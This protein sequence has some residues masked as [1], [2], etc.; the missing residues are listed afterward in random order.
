[1]S[2]TAQ[3]SHLPRCVAKH[4]LTTYFGCDYNFL[5]SRLLPEELLRSWGYDLDEVKRYRRFDTDLTDRIYFHHQITDLN[6]D[7]SAEMAARIERHRA[8][9]G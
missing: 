5:W 7:Y 4:E 3:G 2:S 1:M 9:C 8:N 6:S